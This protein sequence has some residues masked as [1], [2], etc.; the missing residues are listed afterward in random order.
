MAGSSIVVGGDAARG[1]APE[2]VDELRPA[3]VVEGDVEEQP[4]AAGRLVEGALDRAARLRRAARRAGRGAGPGR[5]AARS[6]AVSLAD[7]R[8]EQAEQPDDFFVGAGPVLAAEGVQRQHRDTAA[9]RVPQ[10]V[11]DRL[12]AG[13]VALE[14]GTSPLRGPSGG[15]R[16]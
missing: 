2:R 5:P 6:S 7:R 3:G 9:D 13:G 11:P 14:L 4:V 10:E 16:P 1:E 15:C 8:L 12:D